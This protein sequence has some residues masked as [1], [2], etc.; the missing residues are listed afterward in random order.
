MGRRLRALARRFLDELD[1]TGGELSLV[2]VRDPEIRALKRTWFGLDEATDVLSFPGID[3]PGGGPRI[4][5]DVVISLDTARRVARELGGTLDQELALYLAHG[6]LH[7][8]GFDHATKRQAQEMIAAEARLLG[9]AGMLARFGGAD[10]PLT[11]RPRSPV[12]RRRPA[13]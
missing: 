3:A 6:V 1:L 2:V 12:T 9:G 5:G 7:L 11:F 13:R 8:L 4:L 10:G